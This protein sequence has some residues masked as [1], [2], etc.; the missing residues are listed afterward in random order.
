VWPH[1]NGIAAMG[2]K[3]YG[4]ADEA[5]RVARDISEAAS[6]FVSYRLP[7]LYAGIERREGTFPVQYR[8]A[9]VPQARA[10][11]TVFHLLQAILGLQA[12]A[13]SQRLYVDPVLPRWLPDIVLRRLDL[14]RARLDIRFW[15]SGTESHWEV[16]SCDGTLDVVQKAWEPWPVSADGAPAG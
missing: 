9:N 14:G 7:E 4:F 13:P 16:L 11:G 5:A 3:R 2:F 1:D 10:A 12:D 6:Y 8:D 15:R